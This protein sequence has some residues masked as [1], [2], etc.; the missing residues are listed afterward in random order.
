MDETGLQLEH[1]PRTVVA[2]K[3]SKYLQSRTSG[4]KETLTIIACINAS[5][6]K[7]PPHIIAKG[8]TQRALHGFDLKNA[9]AGAKW[10]VSTKG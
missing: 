6:D 10:S 4:N 5:G 1:V 7:I 8:E 2:R 3:G 9:P